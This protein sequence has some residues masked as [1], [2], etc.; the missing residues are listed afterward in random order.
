MRFLA[1]VLSGLLAACQAPSIQP[2]K[3]STTAG[4]T[5]EAV[6]P[7]VP[8]VKPP[9]LVADSVVISIPGDSPYV[10]TAEEFNDIVN[11][12]PTLYD[13]FPEH[14]DISYAQSGQFRSFVDSMGREKTISFSSEVGKDQYHVLYAYFLKKLHGEA[15]LNGKRDTLVS[16][17]RHVNRI[18]GELKGGGTYFGHQ[19]YRILG[20]AEWGLHQYKYYY[21]A[22]G[23]KYSIAGQKRLYLALLRRKIDD[24]LSTSYDITTENKATLRKQMAQTVAELDSLI[25]DIFY[26]DKTTEFQ[27]SSY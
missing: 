23:S 6:K 19:Y 13:S 14:P 22:L 16:I 7:G 17:Y 10:Y 15:V 4:T 1:Y 26:L 11:N 3:G 2:T 9:Y 8:A 21:E 24:E 18:F 20:Y 5:K 27:Y 25:T 12:F